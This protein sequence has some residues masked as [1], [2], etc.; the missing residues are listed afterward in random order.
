MMSNIREVP[1]AIDD[2]LKYHAISLPYEYSD[3][4]FSMNFL[5]PYSDQ[6]LET[7]IHQLKAEDLRHLLSPLYDHRQDVH[8]KIP[9]M[10]F[11]WSRDVKESLKDLGI[12]NLFQRANLGDLTSH[13]A[14]LVVS[15]VTHA[16]EM[17]VHETGTVATAVT[18]AAIQKRSIQIVPKNPI[19]FFLNR[20]FM[21][22][23]R[24]ECTNTI[25]FSGL[26]YEP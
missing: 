19:E 4:D 3:G 15:Q 5:L 21:F 18:V 25:L 14:N 12:R 13:C 10:K 7:L 20:P 2:S 6:S 9:R 24:H 23:I 22:F 26:V 17:E 1:Y 16:T 11:D 8:Y